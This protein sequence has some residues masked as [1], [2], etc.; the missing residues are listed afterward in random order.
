MRDSKF[1]DTITKWILTNYDVKRRRQI[2]GNYPVLCGLRKNT[3]RNL[4]GDLRCRNCKEMLAIE[5]IRFQRS[6]HPPYSTAL[7]PNRFPRVA[8]SKFT[9]TPFETRKQANFGDRNNEDRFFGEQFYIDIYN[10]LI[11]QHRTC[12]HWW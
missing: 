2:A 10:K 9:F 5:S 6:R 1:G 7:T 12:L 4:H 3:H 11:H 8:G